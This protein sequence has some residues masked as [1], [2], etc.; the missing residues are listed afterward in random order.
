MKKKTLTVKDIH[1]LDDFL[2]FIKSLDIF[3]EN[4]DPV[5]KRHGRNSL[6]EPDFAPYIYVYWSTGG[7]GGGSCWDDGTE[8]VR[9]YSTP[10]SKPEELFDLDTIIE[11]VKPD[12][13]LM[14]Y[15]SLCNKLVEYDEYTENEYYGNSSNYAVKKCN[16]AKLYNE[17]VERNWL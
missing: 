1:S 15:K 5:T 13:T 11:K 9:H 10:G 6:Q 8:P 4:G 7:I 17:F 12:I 16:L 14:Q 2:K 3:I